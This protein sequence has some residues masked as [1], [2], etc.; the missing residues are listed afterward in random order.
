[1]R[2][3]W[4]IAFAAAAGLPAA[5]SHAQLAPSYSGISSEPRAGTSEEFW[6][7]VSSL[8]NCIARLKTDQSR[9]LLGTAPA[10]PAEAK[11][12]RAMLGRTTGCLQYASRMVAPSDLIRG[13]I[14]EGLYKRDVRVPPAAID[15][16]R[17]PRMDPQAG[18]AIKPYRVLAD[19]ARCFASKHPDRVHRMITQTYLGTDKAH[20]AINALEPDAPEC[21]PP[22]MKIQF[23]PTEIRLALVEALYRRAV[24]VPTAPGGSQ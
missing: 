14:V 15:V 23:E 11:A 5:T 7:S 1:M 24:A 22:N 13:A 20:A 17:P 16:P 9:A 18:A 10:S 21:L 3:V 12:I 2:I 19:F 6:F 4:L 8:G